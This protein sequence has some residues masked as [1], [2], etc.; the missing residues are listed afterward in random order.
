MAKK[1][2]S[3]ENYLI[4]TDTVSGIIQEY[5]KQFVRYRYS[6]DRIW[7]SDVASKSNE[8]DYLLSDIVDLNGA[9][10]AST[11]SLLSFLRL[12]TANFNS[13]NS[14]TGW[15]TYVDTQYSSGSPFSITA[16]TNTLLPNNA[17]SVIDSQKPSHVSTFWD[18][19]TQK[20][21]GRNGDNLDFMLY[22]KY[23]PSATNAEVDMWIDIGGSIGELY[24]QSFL[25]RGTEVKSIL[26][27]L[28]S[29]YTLGTW[30]S[31]GASIYIRS[32]KSAVIHGMNFNFDISHKAR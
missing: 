15:A 14:A 32:T 31:N 24:R 25:F 22:F 28:P 11:A 23:Q 20:I 16:D 6:E 8:K 5:P 13:P 1:F 19:A 30:Q 7:I 4:V 26:Y 2:E 27:T 18:S 12:N 9:P 29:A 10:F 3:I 21:T 17:G